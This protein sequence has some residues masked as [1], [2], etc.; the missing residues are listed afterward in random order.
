MEVFLEITSNP[1]ESSIQVVY[2]VMHNT[3]INELQWLAP[4]LESPITTP[5]E[6]TYY[7]KAT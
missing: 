7:P 5:R 6:S 1:S 2:R 3:K 4:Y